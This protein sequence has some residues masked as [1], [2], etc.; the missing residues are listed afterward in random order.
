MELGGIMP[1]KDF[2]QQR[3]I[4]DLK[5]EK[6]PSIL[7]IYKKPKDNLRVRPTQNP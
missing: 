4:R 3:Q 7:D 6:K 5:S 1:A 2:R